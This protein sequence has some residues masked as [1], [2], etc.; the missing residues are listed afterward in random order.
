MASHCRIPLCRDCQMIEDSKKK[1]I[2]N[3][4]VCGED[5]R[6]KL[7]SS[8]CLALFHKDSCIFYLPSD[9]QHRYKRP[10]GSILQEMCWLCDW[11]VGKFSLNTHLPPPHTSTMAYIGAPCRGTAPGVEKESRGLASP[12]PKLLLYINWQ[13]RYLGT[14]SFL[15]DTVFLRVKSPY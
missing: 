15:C 7:S 9:Q 14:S 12:K 8:S 10:Y 3:A 13:V 2:K 4:S 1:K 11:S 6:Y 5:R